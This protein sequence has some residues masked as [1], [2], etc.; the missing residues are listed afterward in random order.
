MPGRL[1][2]KIA[3]VFGAGSVGPGWGNGKATATLFAR[4]GAHVVCVDFNPEAAKETVAIIEAEGGSAVAATCDVTNSDQI[5][6][7]VDGIVATRGRIDVLHNNVGYATMGGP[8]ELTEAEW[9]KTFDLNI[10][11]CFLS[12]KHVLPH[13]LSRRSGAIVNVSSIAAIRWTGYP[14]AAYYA[15]KAAVNNFTMGLALQYAQDGIRANAVMPGLMNTPLIH[16]QISGQYES[17]EDMVRARDAVCPM[18]RMG[19]AWD[20]AQ[21]ALFLAS[22]EAGY[23]TGVSLPVDGGLACRA[24]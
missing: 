9:H 19:T 7:V 24:A 3:I 23:I 5:K 2:D 13:M 10:T 11:G 16:Q 17:A 21:A 12:C 18:G 8:I 1:Q 15:A 20:V 14:Y 4:E 22:D 6:T